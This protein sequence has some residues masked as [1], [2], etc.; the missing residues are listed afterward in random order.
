M[1]TIASLSNYFMVISS[2]LIWQV[3]LDFENKVLHSTFNNTTNLEVSFWVWVEK[4]K[5][6][7]KK[8]HGLICL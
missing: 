1:T 4:L 5:D 7:S 6:S 3:L 2:W 8:D